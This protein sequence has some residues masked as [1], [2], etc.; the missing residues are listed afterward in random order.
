MVGPVDDPVVGAPP[1]DV[2]S[3]PEEADA[4]GPGDVETGEP[5]ATR[6][7]MNESD[8]VPIIALVTIIARAVLH[9]GA[10]LPGGFFRR[11]A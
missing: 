10:G 9:G 2:D 5:H 7:P 4:S 1:G 6:A 11:K 3:P 8:T